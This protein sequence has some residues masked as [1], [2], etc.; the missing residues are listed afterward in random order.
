[1]RTKAITR[2]TAR[3]LGACAAAAA[4][5]LATPSTA[6]AAQGILFIDG[7]PNGNPSGCFPLGDFAPS[8]VVNF[9]DGVAWVWSGPAC[10]GRVVQAILPG[11]LAIGHGR[12]L[13]IE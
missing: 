4:L 2:R 6:H 3:L 8:E 1:M 7:A 13:F 10:D 9:T 12:S 11:Q 5:A